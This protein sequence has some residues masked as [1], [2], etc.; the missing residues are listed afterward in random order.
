M[1]GLRTTVERNAVRSYVRG[2]EDTKFHVDKVTMPFLLPN[3]KLKIENCVRS[4]G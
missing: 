2:D 4:A 3:N 1:R